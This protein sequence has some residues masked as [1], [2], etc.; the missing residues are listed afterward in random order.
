MGFLRTLLGGTDERPTIV[1]RTVHLLKTDNDIGEFGEWMTEYA[2]KNLMGRYYILRNLYIPYKGRTSEIDLLLVHERGICVIESKNYSGWIFGKAT[3]R[4]W[5]QSLNKNSKS[6]FYNPIL[7]NATHIKA[8]VEYLDLPDQFRPKSYIVFSER[9][10]LKSVPDSTDE[11]KICK[12][13]DMMKLLRKDLG[14][15]QH[16]LDPETL[17][18]YKAK[19]QQCAGANKE[20]KEAHIEQVQKYKKGSR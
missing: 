8:L 2:L 5:T 9:C 14:A 18:S 16:I 4:Y 12:R 17:E 6:R 11:I 10:E 13:N 19:L 20:T 7:Q 3:D 15:C 1:E